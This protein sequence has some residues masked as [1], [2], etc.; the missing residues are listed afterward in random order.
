[1][2]W[3]LAS[4]QQWQAT[5]V[6]YSTSGINTGYGR[7]SSHLSWA[8]SSLRS[9]TTRSSSRVTRRST[10]CTFRASSGRATGRDGGV[11]NSTTMWTTKRS[12]R[13]LNTGL[14]LRGDRP[15]TRIIITI[16][17]PSLQHR[18]RLHARRKLALRQY[19]DRSHTK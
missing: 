4:S 17:E 3:A 9:S 10:L 14:D 8:R 1:V 7:V 15:T 13:V 11:A 5:G 2:T 19:V 16:P 12:S 6:R 18:S